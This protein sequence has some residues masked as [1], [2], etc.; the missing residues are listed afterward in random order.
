MP[1]TMEL[2]K[3]VVETG[4]QL[5][6][7]RLVAGTWGNISVR[8][9]DGA[10]IFITPSGQPYDELI[11][12][13]IVVV[14]VAG[15]IVEGCRPS[16]EL[17]L[18]LAIYSARP[19]VRAVVHTHSLFATACAVDGE[20]I[21]PCLEELV[22]AVG[23][24]VEVAEYALPG[25]P[26]LATSAVFALGDRSAVLLANHG[27]AACGPSLKEALLVAELVEKAAQIHVI[28]RQLGG[29]RQWSDEDIHLM[30]QFYLEKYMRR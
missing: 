7:K 18:H 26:A 14:D 17:A 20:P 5:M 16:S 25:T 28:A 12:E 29:T 8:S 11:P 6:D 2:K 3:A 4:R 9:D 19:D 30:R 23:G 27:V 22:Q 13:D 1:E 24:G 10:R 15:N 21:P